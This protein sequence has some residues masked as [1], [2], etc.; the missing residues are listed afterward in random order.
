MLHVSVIIES[1]FY[2][3]ITNVN[4]VLQF[5]MSAISFC[6]F[7]SDVNF[8]HHNCRQFNVEIFTLL[9]ELLNRQVVING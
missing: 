5:Q 7:S 3:F 1:I 6:C 8:V 4:R 2:V 9:C